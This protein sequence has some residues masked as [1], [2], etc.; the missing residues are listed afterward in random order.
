MFPR[1]GPGSELALPG[2]STALPSRPAPAVELG[3]GLRAA[4]LNAVAES[5]L[6]WAFG[7]RA[8]ERGEVLPAYVEGRVLWRGDAGQASFGPVTKGRLGPAE[9][10]PLKA[11]KMSQ[12]AQKWGG[13]A[14]LS[15]S[16]R[17]VRKTKARTSWHRQVR[18]LRFL[19]QLWLGET[20]RPVD[21]FKEDSGYEGCCP[22]EYA[23]GL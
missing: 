2:V 4:G 5:L 10:G 15:D 14:R 17:S 23:G 12:S 16:L 21:L 22:K 1:G 6:P 3:A 9:L 13:S 11:R 19:G 7:R 20:E 8:S 18:D